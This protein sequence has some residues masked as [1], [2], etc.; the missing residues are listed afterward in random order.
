MTQSLASKS[1]EIR[2]QIVD[3]VAALEGTD[4]LEL[5]PLYDVV[6]PDAL[7]SI[8]SPTISG[9]ARV[10]RIEFPYAGHTITVEVEDE[11]VVRIE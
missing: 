6:E 8:F 1:H 5:P 9:T 3:G 11:P 2:E 10:G 7:E 4:P